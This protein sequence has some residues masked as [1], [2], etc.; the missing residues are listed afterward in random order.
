[1]LIILAILQVMLQVLDIVSTVQVLKRSG[2]ELNPFI[3]S[4]GNKWK[5]V[6]IVV[7]VGIAATM[8]LLK[9]ITGLIIVDAI[10]LV[11]VVWNVYQL[12]KEK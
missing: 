8:Y 11:V 7:G 4:L 5:V 9:S 3:N 6:K 10:M 2:R 12:L 1:M